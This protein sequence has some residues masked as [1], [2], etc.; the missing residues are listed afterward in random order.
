MRARHSP[1]PSPDSLT[2]GARAVH[3]EPAHL[4]DRHRPRCD[5][6]PCQ[7]LGQFHPHRQSLL[8]HRQPSNHAD[9]QSDD[10]SVQ[11][12]T[13]RATASSLTVQVQP[14]AHTPVTGNNPYSGLRCAGRSGAYSCPAGSTLCLTEVPYGWSRVASFAERRPNASDSSYAHHLSAP[15]RRPPKDLVLLSSG[16]TARPRQ[17]PTTF[18]RALLKLL[19]VLG[20]AQKIR[21][22]RIPEVVLYL[23][24]TSSSPF[25]PPPLRLDEFPSDI[26]EQFQILVLPCDVLDRGVAPPEHRQQRA[27]IRGQL[28]SRLRGTARRVRDCQR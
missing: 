11:S 14:R 26:D 27:R 20:R 16:R 9:E 2:P 4:P 1:P 18:P 10:E 17:G 21:P 8:D 25:R 7:H 3:P 28:R 22:V 19:H 24:V 5:R 23:A 6:R 13:A 12:R 15:R